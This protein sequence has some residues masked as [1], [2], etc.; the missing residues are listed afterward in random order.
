[1]C[2]LRF[3]A[4]SDLLTTCRFYMIPA[5]G[6]MAS[7]FG[8]PKINKDAQVVNFERRPIPGLYAAGG[9]WVYDDIGGNQLGGGMVF[10]RVAARH[11]AGRAA[12]RKNA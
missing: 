10:G 3:W 11:A 8:G 9:V 1:K 7:T 4:L 2:L 6:G 5:A 12:S